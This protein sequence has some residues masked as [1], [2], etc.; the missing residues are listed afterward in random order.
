MKSLFLDF[1]LPALTLALCLSNVIMGTIWLARRP[2]TA[3]VADYHSE[4]FKPGPPSP[5]LGEYTPETYRC[6][7]RGVEAEC[8]STL[9]SASH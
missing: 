5:V 6:R 2:E 8:T 1:V 4:A 9:Y 7:G 3:L